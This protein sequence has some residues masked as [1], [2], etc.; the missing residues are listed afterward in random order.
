MGLKISKRNK[1]L[2]YGPPSPYTVATQSETESETDKCFIWSTVSPYNYTY[3]IDDFDLECPF[4]KEK[5]NFG[6]IITLP[7]FSRL[8]KT[9]KKNDIINSYNYGK[10]NNLIIIKKMIKKNRLNFN[11]CLY[12]A[13]ISNNEIV[14]YL[15]SDYRYELD[16][17]FY[18]L[19]LCQGGHLDNVKIELP[20][21]SEYINYGLW[22]SS[23]GGKKDVTNYLLK[24]GASNFNFALYGAS[25]SDN[26]ENVMYILKKININYYDIDYQ[27]VIECALKM[28]NFV[29]ADYI[30][31]I[32]G[33]STSTIH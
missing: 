25:L 8:N 2:P 11:W 28:N 23:L 32:K 1:I 9:K 5:L 24:N 16:S 21:Y 12:G 26:I 3:T 7:M 14:T 22:A 20:N 33:L 19:G 6:N 4:T 15:S 13:S 31:K 10:N 29:I 18:F 17:R 27:G 30:E